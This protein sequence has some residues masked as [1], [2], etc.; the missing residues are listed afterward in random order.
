M[1]ELANMNGCP[2]SLACP[3][4][5]PPVLLSSSSYCQHGQRVGGRN[6]GEDRIGYT[7]ARDGE[8]W[9]KVTKS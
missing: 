7:Q 5:V 6:G 4:A 2:V 1:K 8:S 3:P 9:L